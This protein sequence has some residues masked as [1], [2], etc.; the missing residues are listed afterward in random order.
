LA[1]LAKSLYRDDDLS[2]IDQCSAGMTPPAFSPHF[3]VA[4][5]HVVR[6]KLHMVVVN[7]LFLTPRTGTVTP[8]PFLMQDDHPVKQD[9]NK[10]FLNPPVDLGP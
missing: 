4:S 8:V 6:G 10:T 7:P 9:G 2:F 5:V 3:P 1:R